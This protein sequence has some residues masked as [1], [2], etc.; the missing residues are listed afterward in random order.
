MW[1]SVNFGIKNSFTERI[2]FLH[3]RTTNSSK[4]L[5]PKYLRV[6][7][8]IF[9]V[10]L[11]HFWF[12]QDNWQIWH[13]WD[14]G[15]LVAVNPGDRKRYAECRYPLLKEVSIFLCVCV[16]FLS[17]NIQVHILCSSIELK[18]CLVK[19]L[20]YLS[21]EGWCFEVCQKLGIDYLGKVVSTSES[22]QDIDKITL[23]RFEL[24]F[25]N[26]KM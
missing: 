3:R 26:L 5:E 9:I 22:N 2:F 10:L 23:F 13:D 24:K 15:A 25:V 7:K 21:R 6:F 17:I 11:Q 16:F 8:N 19:I 12:P 14:R 18:G 4:F 20:Q 1:K